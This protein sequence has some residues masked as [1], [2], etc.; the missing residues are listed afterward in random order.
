VKLAEISFKLSE[1][2]E[3]EAQ[4]DAI[5]R[6]AASPNIDAYSKLFAMKMKAF[7]CSLNGE[8][9]KKMQILSEL[10]KLTS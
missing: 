9:E 4:V 1:Y 8:T 3:S 10:Q 7:F 5:L 6:R 2:E